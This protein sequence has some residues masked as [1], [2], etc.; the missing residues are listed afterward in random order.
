[1][2]G[3][4][5]TQKRSLTN[6]QTDERNENEVNEARDGL[7]GCRNKLQFLINQTRRKR[8]DDLCKEP[9]YENLGTG[10]KIV[11]KMRMGHA[12]FNIAVEQKIKVATTLFPRQTKGWRLS[13]TEETFHSRTAQ[14]NSRKSSKAPGLP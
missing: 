4:P 2:T 3:M 5:W 14:K 11:E 9:E 8:R 1:M 6:E 10:Y 13:G 12:P 7:R